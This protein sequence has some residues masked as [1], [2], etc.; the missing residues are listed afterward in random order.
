MFLQCVSFIASCTLLLGKLII[1]Y[2]FPRALL[3]TALEI[4]K[5]ASAK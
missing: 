5:Y 2:V 3:S 4:R 1:I